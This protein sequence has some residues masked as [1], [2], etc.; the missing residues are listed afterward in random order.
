MKSRPAKERLLGYEKA[1]EAN[2]IPID[3]EY[4][5]YGD[6]THQTAYEITKRI[7]KM[8]NRPTAIFVSSNTIF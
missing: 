3:N 1:L 4:I 5:F 6:Y 2:N 8:D 7:L